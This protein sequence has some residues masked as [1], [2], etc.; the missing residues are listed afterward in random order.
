MSE[1]PYLDAPVSVLPKATTS[2]PVGTETVGEFLA[3]VRDGRHRT[4]VEAIRALDRKD[5]RDIAK[6]GL[7]GCTFAGRFTT[8][9]NAGLV[10]PSGVVC[11]D[12]DDLPDVEAVRRRLAECPHVLFVFESVSGPRKPGLKVGVPV[13]PPPTT[14]AEARAAY[15]AAARAVGLS[16]EVDPAAK[17]LARL[18]FTSSDPHLYVNPEAVPVT[19]DFTTAGPGL[20]RGPGEEVDR[21][22]DGRKYVTLRHFGGLL[23]YGGA[24]PEVI[25]TALHAIHERHSDV[26]GEPGPIDRLAAWFGTLDPDERGSLSRYLTDVHTPDA[27]TSPTQEVGAPAFAPFPTDVLPRPVA[28]YVRAQAS[29]LNVD[30]SAVAVPVLVALGAAVG[31]SYEVEPKPGW[32]ERAAFWACL[33]QPSGTLKSQSVFVAVEPALKL[34][35]EAA[36][37]YRTERDDYE[38]NLSQWNELSKSAKAEVPKPSKPDRRRYRTGD[39]TV[40]SLVSVHADATRGL[41]VYRD[42]LSGWLGSFDRYARGDADQANWI[43][44]CGGR[45]IVIDRKSDERG[46]LYVER[47]NASVVGTIQPSTLAAKLGPGHFDSGFAARLLLTEPPARRRRWSEATVT[48]DVAGAYHS[49]VRGLY[50]ED[51]GADVLPFSAEARALFVAFYNE[52]GAVMDRLPDGPL[53]A[54]LSKVEGYCVRLALV[55]HLCACAV[56]REIPGEVSAEAV[57]RAVVVA[58]W[59]RYEQARVYRLHGFDRLALDADERKALELPDEFGWGDVADVWEVSRSGAF[60]VIGRLLEKRCAEDAGHGKYRRVARLPDDLAAITFDPEVSK[61]HPSTV[62]SGDGLATDLPSLIEPA[63]DAPL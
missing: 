55:F 21:L 29:A 20:G 28:D 16:A 18:C 46:V 3:G 35:K 38:A 11:L 23:R 2:R 48:S 53:R 63:T 45:P 27:P 61:V 50:R 13:T 47:P 34:E 5:A 37:R 56:R 54:S 6:K 62:P 12:A 40:E 43:E 49:L 58:R 25:A 19:V 7:P 36:D 15:D 32:R 31:N 42:E 8:R 52:N 10:D 59:L 17:D 26:P 30:E 4:R 41:L 60:K 39:T 24:S 57:E 14:N 9:N 33:I 1:R 22:E 44:L 51:E